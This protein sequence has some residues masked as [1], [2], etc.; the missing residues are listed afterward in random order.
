ME[1]RGTVEVVLS[2]V[3][4][5]RD[6]RKKGIGKQLLKACDDVVKVCLSSLHYQ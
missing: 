1:E 6:K 3:A 5:R 2:N 4:V